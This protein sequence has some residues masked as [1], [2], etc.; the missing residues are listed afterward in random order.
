MMRS[1]AHIIPAELELGGPATGR[2]G[3]VGGPPTIR[4]LAYGAAAVEDPAP[5][6]VEVEK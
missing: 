4:R 2:E 3:T 1:R 6:A 5:A